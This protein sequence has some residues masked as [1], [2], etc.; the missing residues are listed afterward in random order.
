MLLKSLIVILSALFSVS[1]MANIMVYPM[2]VQLDASK[3]N[4][5][6][7]KII[8]KSDTTQFVRVVI[9]EVINP[10]TPDEHEQDVA[11]WQGQGI[12]VSP[13]KFALSAG[14]TKT[15]RIVS[16]ATPAQE[17]VYRAYFE[18]V[19]G[20]TEGENS[21]KSPKAA[22]ALTLVWGVL[23]RQI[24]DHPQLSMQRNTALNGI[25]NNGNVRIRLSGYSNCAPAVSAEKCPVKP[26]DQ[27][28]YPGA[29]LSLPGTD[30]NKPLR[31]EYLTEDEKSLSLTL[32]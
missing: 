30:V 17:R 31:I 13:A 24:P 22:V 18:P 28:I 27:R 26:L 32:P 12:V 9:K 14:T 25:T 7:L 15:V 11:S 20:E 4:A 5:T 1:A 6:T 21:V 10:A 16:L 3:K 8:S 19:S 23:V 29:S 2:S